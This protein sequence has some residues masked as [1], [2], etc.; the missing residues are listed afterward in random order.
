MKFILGKKLQMTQ[1]FNDTGVVPVTVVSAGPCT[2]TYVKGEKD[3]YRAIQI[4]FETSRKKLT[5]SLEGHLK[6]LA[7][8]KFLG[9]FRT[10]AEAKRG[11]M[12]SVG[13]FK[14]GD[15]VQVTGVSKGKGFQGVV[16][17]HH[18]SG[19]PKTHG[20]KDQLR[21]P[22]SIG[23][24]EPKHVLRGTRMGG[25][26]G[27]DQVTV[28]NLEVVEVDEAKNLLYLKGAVPGAY[29]AVLAISGEGEAVFGEPAAGPAANE[30][31]KADVTTG[32]EAQEIKPE[33]A[34]ESLDAT[35]TVPAAAAEQVRVE[36]KEDKK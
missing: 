27:A 28:K 24:T 34:P 30:E 10:D 15:T 36:K 16:K 6:D 18:F 9:E 12:L 33:A 8:F 11:Q 14:P 35:E 7:H 5:K 26:L 3:G 13:M 25:H 21:M 23:A 2:V 4:G 17:R 32:H 19:S 29:H 22:G 20:H 1:R 31:N